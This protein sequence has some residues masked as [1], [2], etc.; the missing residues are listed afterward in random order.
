MKQQTD[1]HTRST[2]NYYE[3]GLFLQ[4]Q[5]SQMSLSRQ[6]ADAHD[7]VKEIPSSVTLSSTQNPVPAPDLDLLIHRRNT[8]AFKIHTNIWYPREA[9]THYAFTII[10]QAIIL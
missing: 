9:E 1:Q 5:L 4:I 6:V 8:P 7:T 2:I 3:Q 10:C